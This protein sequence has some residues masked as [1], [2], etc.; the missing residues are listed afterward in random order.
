MSTT[1][2][3]YEK[4]Y[5]RFD[6]PIKTKSFFLCFAPHI[7]ASQNHKTKQNDTTQIPLYH[8]SYD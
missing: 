3:N 5:L 4:K 7:I 2:L 1:S 8:L 6:K